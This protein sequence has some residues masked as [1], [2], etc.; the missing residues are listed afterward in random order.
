MSRRTSREHA[1]QA[2]YECEFHQDQEE[3]V[4]QRR[5]SSLQGDDAQFYLD[6]VQG[7][8]EQQASIDPVIQ[9]FLKEGWSLSRIPTVDR[10]IL[11]L[12]V[13]E[14]LYQPETPQGAILNEAV[15]LGKFFSSEESGRFINGV[16][17]MVVKEIN[18]IKA[19]I[20]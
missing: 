16:L 19:E 8:Q 10:A 3:Q 9:R 20:E 5:G 2:L 6:L 17:G 11:R 12:A 14:L 15:D 7:I 13:Y 1:I 18:Q 4:I